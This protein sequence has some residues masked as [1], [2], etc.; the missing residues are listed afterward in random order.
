MKR[1]YERVGVREYIIAVPRDEKLVS[2][3]RT[4]T[5][6]FQP[7]ES[8]ADGIYRSVFFPGCWLDVAALWSLDLQRMNLILR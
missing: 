3:P 2:L 7:L 1:L 6:G 5:A 4:P 8:G